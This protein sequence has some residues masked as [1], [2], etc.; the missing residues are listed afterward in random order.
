MPI[1]YVKE[2]LETD[3]HGTKLDKIQE[4]YLAPIL[5]D[6]E[7]LG[8]LTLEKDSEVFKGSYSVNGQTITI[9]VEFE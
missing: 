8:H 7:V 2:I 6:D 4:K 5:L 3:I 9:Y 1:L